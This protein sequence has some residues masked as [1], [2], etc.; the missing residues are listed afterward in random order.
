MK[1]E[2]L[3]G[4]SGNLFKNFITSE[5]LFGTRVFVEISGDNPYQTLNPA[6]FTKNIWY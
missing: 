2:Y 6:F 4:C 3:R 5:T 1:E